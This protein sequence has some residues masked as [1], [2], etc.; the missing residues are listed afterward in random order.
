MDSVLVTGHV[1]TL[2]NVIVEV[3]VTGTVIMLELDVIVVYVTGQVVVVITC[4]PK[5]AFDSLSRIPAMHLLWLTLSFLSWFSAEVV[6]ERS[7]SAWD[8]LHCR[9]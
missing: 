4:A 7:Q 3:W 5:L 2:V 9:R 8:S 1:V 6:V